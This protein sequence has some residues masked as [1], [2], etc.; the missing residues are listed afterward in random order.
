MESAAGA[1]ASAP[2]IRLSRYLE[3]PACTAL[4]A[5]YVADSVAGAVQSFHKVDAF[6]P[7]LLK[8]G[9][10]HFARRFGA[11]AAPL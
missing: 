11:K 10:R 9:E 5:V 8:P 4:F 3:L 2:P 6:R 1:G 7:A